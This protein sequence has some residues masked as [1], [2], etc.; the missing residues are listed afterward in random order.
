[1]VA[2]NVNPISKVMLGLD[3]NT[4]QS[5]CLSGF[6]FTISHC[7]KDTPITAYQYSRIRL[8]LALQRKRTIVLFLFSF[9]SI[10]YT[11]CALPA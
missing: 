9:Y 1:M 11:L 2:R 4:H 10:R 3:G 6:A 8:S 5:D 7:L